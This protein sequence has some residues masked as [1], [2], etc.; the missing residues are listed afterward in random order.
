[1]ESRLTS[2]HTHN[3][4][5][6]ILI[7]QSNPI[8]AKPTLQ[9]TKRERIKVKLKSAEKSEKQLTSGLTMRVYGNS[10]PETPTIGGQHRVGVNDESL[11]QTLTEN[12]TIGW[13]LRV[14]DPQAANVGRPVSSDP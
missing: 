11:R 1:M 10:S 14:V 9:N 7:Q 8:I 3:P 6:V 12:P 2:G 13:A 5:L 4:R